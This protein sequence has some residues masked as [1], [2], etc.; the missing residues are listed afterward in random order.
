MCGIIAFLS[1]TE[2]AFNYLLNGLIIL[3][4]RGYD[5]AGI[6]FISDKKI[7]VKKS[8]GRISKLK[9]LI[10]DLDSSKINVG[11]GATLD[12]Y[13]ETKKRSPLILQQI[14]LEWLWRLLNKRSVSH[15]RDWSDCLGCA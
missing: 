3:Q 1:K 9:E 5:S 8:K 13:T 2:F 12:Y 10:E 15:V 7:K 4:N 6:A 11:I 14:G